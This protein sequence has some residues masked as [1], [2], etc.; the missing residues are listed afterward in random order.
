MQ[1][2]VVASF[3]EDSFCLAETSHGARGHSR[4]VFKRKSQ[5]LILQMMLDRERQLIFIENE[6]APA[7]RHPQ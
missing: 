1:Y 2:S 4:V 7:G 3:T 5:D 6:K